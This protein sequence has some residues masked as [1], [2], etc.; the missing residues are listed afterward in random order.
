MTPIGNV[1][2]GEHCEGV[3]GSSGSHEQAEGVRRGRVVVADDAAARR[4]LGWAQVTPTD[5]R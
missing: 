5:I 4:R 3:G 2:E 1:N